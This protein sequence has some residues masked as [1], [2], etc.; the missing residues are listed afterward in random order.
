MWNDS[1][2]V[3]LQGGNRILDD[4]VC[5]VR[6]KLDAISTPLIFCEGQQPEVT[7]FHRFSCQ[8]PIQA[9][10]LNSFIN[11]RNGYRGHFFDCPKK[12]E[13]FNLNI[14]QNVSQEL[15]SIYNSKTCLPPLLTREEFELSLKHAKVWVHEQKTVAEANSRAE[16]LG[17]QR[18]SDENWEENKSKLKEMLANESAAGDR[19][20]EY[21]TSIFARGEGSLKNIGTHRLWPTHLTIKGAFVKGKEMK[22]TLNKEYRSITIHCLGAS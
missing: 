12:G 19:S 2:E 21:F 9:D 22:Q 14:I 1:N 4:I 20:A 17:S 16:C 15:M 8:V 18:W 6:Q 5:C 13:E 11:S 7:R 3:T 10:L